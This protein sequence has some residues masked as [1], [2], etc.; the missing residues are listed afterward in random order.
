[1]RPSV[2]GNDPEECPVHVVVKEHNLSGILDD[3]MRR[4]NTRHAWSLALEQCIGLDLPVAQTF[5]FREEL[6]FV[7]GKIRPTITSAG[8]ISSGGT[9]LLW[10]I[11][12][13]NRPVRQSLG[14]HETDTCAVLPSAIQVRPAV[15]QGRRRFC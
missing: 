2:G 1:M 12:H 15:G 5:D 3:F 7:L 4:S 14:S 11:D 8:E 13:A 6:G 9:L 10:T